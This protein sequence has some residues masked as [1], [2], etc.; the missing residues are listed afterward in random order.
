MCLFYFFCILDSL[1]YYF[2]YSLVISFFFNI[3]NRFFNVLVI[4]EL[5][6]V[7]SSLLSF[8]I[9]IFRNWI[10][11]V[12]FFFSISK[13]AW[14]FIFGH[15]QNMNMKSSLKRLLPFLPEKYVCNN[16]LHI[17]W[18][19]KFT[20]NRYPWTNFTKQNAKNKD[21]EPWD[22]FYTSQMI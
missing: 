11:Q 18:H 9:V 13:N 20:L 7:L 4:Y 6:C 17:S 22:F 5:S 10:D 12:M 21:F 8:F 2:L 1:I 15:Y 14:Q 3:L 16:L 19:N